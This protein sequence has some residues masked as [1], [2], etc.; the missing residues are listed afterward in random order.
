[1][2]AFLLQVIE[3]FATT[4]YNKYRKFMLKL[5]YS[6]LQDR[7]FSED[8]VQNSMIRIDENKGRIKDVDSDKTKNFIYTITKNAAID[9]YRKNKSFYANNDRFVNPNTLTDIDGD[10]DVEAFCDNLALRSEIR[11]ALLEL[12]PEDRDLICYKYGAGETAKS[13]SKMTGLNTDAVSYRLKCI[14]K[15]LKEALKSEHENQ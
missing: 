12:S 7:Q 1:M 10:A 13:I 3:D 9:I 5:A 6:I 15:K 4:I 11:K 14:K 8:A 2:L